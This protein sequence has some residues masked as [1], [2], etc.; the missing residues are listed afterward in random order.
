MSR[1]CTQVREVLNLTKRLEKKTLCFWTH[2]NS[3]VLKKFQASVEY[4]F[5]KLIRLQFLTKVIL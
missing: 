5:P 1:H 2:T 4:T 3:Q